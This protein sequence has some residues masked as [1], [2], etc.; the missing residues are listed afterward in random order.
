MGRWLFAAFLALALLYLIPIWSVDHLPTSDGPA[1]LYN[2]WVLR[3]LITGDT[4]A[5]SRFYAIDWKPHPNWIGHAALALLMCIVPPVIAEKILFSAIVLLFLWSI[6][7]YSSGPPY[8]FIAFPFAYHQ[9]LQLGYYNFSISIGLYFLIL[10]IWWRRRDRPEAKTIAVI[11]LLLIV[12]YFAHP[13]STVL[14]MGSVGLLW[15]M[16]LPG[17]TLSVHTRHLLAFVPVLPLLLWFAEK[18]GTTAYPNAAPFI[19]RLVALASINPLYTF[20]GRQI[21]LGFSLTILL[22]TFAVITVIVDRLR[23]EERAFLVLTAVFLIIYFVAPEGLAGGLGVTQRVSF[24]IY[25]LPLPWFT[26][27]LPRALRIAIVAVLSI[28]AVVYLAYLIDRYRYT[29]R[30]LTQFLSSLEA[31]PKGSTLLPLLFQ[32]RPPNVFVPVYSHLVDYAAVDK[33]LVDLGNYEP[34]TGYFPIRFRPGVEANNLHL[35]EGTPSELDIAPFAARAQCIFTWRMGRYTPIEKRIEERYTLVSDS[36]G[37]RV[38]RNLRLRPPAISAPS[39][40][41]LPVA[42]TVGETRGWRV[43]QNVRNAGGSPVHLA[44]NPCAERCEFDLAPGEQV[45][46]ASMDEQMPFMIVYPAAAEGSGAPQLIFTTIVSHDDTPLVEIPAVPESAFQRRKIRIPNVPFGGVKLNLRAWFL[47]NGPNLFFIRIRSRDGR[48]LGQKLEGIAP[49]AFFT[50]A[51]LE[52]T[53]PQISPSEFVDV[54]IDSQS[55]DMRLWA[56]V[57]AT[58]FNAGRVKLHLPQGGM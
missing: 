33:R 18:S 49:T 54:E 3:E 45:P 58:D 11:A 47:G 8:A 27:Q 57:T 25:L 17:R 4:G 28:I 23:G 46:L 56:F 31:V 43:D 37:G 7:M 22:I 34:T 5:V 41:L 55:D 14:A 53:F 10:A 35:I 30:F 40:I 29:D 38:Y 21:K 36:A 44:L 19:D 2:S 24:F 1:H 13:M 48:L 39:M 20:D 12:C 16:T 52:T 26:R 32:H 6:W 51:S 50:N 9:F 15:L 42:G